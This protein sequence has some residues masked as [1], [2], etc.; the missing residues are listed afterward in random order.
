[1]KPLRLLAAAGVTMAVAVSTVLLAPAASASSPT[2]TVHTSGSP[3]ALRSSPS[4][5]AGKLRDVASGTRITISCQATGS[6]VS[7]KY[8]T[9]RIWDKTTVGGK[10]GYV[11]DAYVYT[12]SDGRVAPNCS[13]PA[14]PKPPTSNQKKIDAV[15]AAAKSQIGHGY[16]YSWAAGGKNGPSYGVCCSPTG[17]NDSHRYGYD[18]SGLTQ[19]AFWKGAH[20]DIGGYTGTQVTKGH[21]LSWAIRKPGDLIFWYTRSGGTDHVAIYIGDNKMI[22]AAPPRGSNSVHITSVYGSH[23]TVVRIIG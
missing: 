17:V 9:S 14:P 21:K 8:G 5:S 18:C 23:S 22:E 2:G 11:S 4:T 12:G 10:T 3:L 20:I 16:S 7:G 6:S 13:T 15:I 1:M 19:F